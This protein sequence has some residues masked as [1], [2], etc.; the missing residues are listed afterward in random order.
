M[1]TVTVTVEGGNV[2]HVDVP[3][4]VEVI[5]LDYDVEGE[6]DTEVEIDGNGDRRKRSVWLYVPEEAE[7]HE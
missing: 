4:G 1:K 3:E 5:I 2:Q 6:P 7:H